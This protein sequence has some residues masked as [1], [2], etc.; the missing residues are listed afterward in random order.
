MQQVHPELAVIETDDRHPSSATVDATNSQH[1][2]GK[3]LCLGLKDYAM[4]QY[5]MLARTVLTH[6]NVRRTEDFG[7]I[8]FAMVDSGELRTSEG[9]SLEDFRSVFNFE[10]V[11]AD[12]RRE[13]TEQR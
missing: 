7:R 13:R 3:Q 10:D 9:D 1:V 4:H 12:L 5:G 2:T 6:W 8:V 11:F